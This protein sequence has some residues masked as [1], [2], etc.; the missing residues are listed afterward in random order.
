M[1]YGRWEYVYAAPFAEALV[2]DPIFRSWVLRRTV[3]AEF[4]DEARLLDQEMFLKRSPGTKTW[5]R[6]HFQEACRCTG[7]SGKETDLL[8]IFHTKAAG[9]FAL[10]LEVKHPGDDFKDGQAAAYPTRANCW[11]AKTPEHVLPHVAATCGL[12]FSE[13]RRDEYAPHLEHFPAKFTF[14][15]IRQQ[16]PNAAPSVDIDRTVL[17]TRR[18]RMLQ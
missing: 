18:D 16:F 6:S 14:D 4:A 13:S 8:A 11:I 17:R 7:C 9:R 1:G 5:W 10:H 12:L 3:F 15:C 2:N